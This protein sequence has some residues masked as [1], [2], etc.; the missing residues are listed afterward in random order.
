MR[1]AEF[2]ALSVLM[3]SHEGNRPKDNWQFDSDA[4]TLAHLARM[5]AF[6]AALKPYLKAAVAE[7]AQAG[8]PVM[9]PLFLDFEE[10]AAAWTIKDEYLL[11]PD[12]LVAPVIV[13]GAVTRRVHLPSGSWKHLWRGKLYSGG[14]MEIA[15]PI[16]EPPIFARASSKWMGVFEEAV[17]VISNQ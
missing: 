16:G 8:I 3:R 5:T 15:A 7:N 12:L 10:D 2:S 4:Q 9:R 11:G 6:H 1:W 17:K 14:D 13:E